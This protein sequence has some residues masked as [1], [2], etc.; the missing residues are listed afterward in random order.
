MFSIKKSIRITAHDLG[1]EKIKYFTALCYKSCFM[2]KK[3]Y[4]LGTKF[5][6]YEKE[7]F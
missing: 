5:K 4:F 6:T 1:N 2:K 3:H 7:Y